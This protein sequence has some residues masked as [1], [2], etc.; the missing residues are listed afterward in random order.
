MT[1]NREDVARRICEAAH[2]TSI[3]EV[4]E[5]VGETAF[6]AGENCTQVKRARHRHAV[7]LQHEKDQKIWLQEVVQ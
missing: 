5:W 4:V 7:L 2:E 1:D 6:D 3:V